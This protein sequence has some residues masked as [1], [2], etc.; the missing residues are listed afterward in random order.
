L[1]P[2]LK[3]TQNRTTPFKKMHGLIEKNSFFS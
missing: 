3:P 2:W 1:T